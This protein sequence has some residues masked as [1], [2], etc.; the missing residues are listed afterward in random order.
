MAGR[1]SN[2]MG[3]TIAQ[4]TAYA[5]QQAEVIIFEQSSHALQLEEPKKFQDSIAAFVNSKQILNDG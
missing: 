3:Q 2:V 1:Y 4:A 5:L